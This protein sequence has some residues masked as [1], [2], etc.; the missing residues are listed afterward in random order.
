MSVH[1]FYVKKLNNCGLQVDDKDLAEKLRIQEKE[2]LLI[3]RTLAQIL[4]QSNIKLP[5][6]IRV[7]VKFSLIFCVKF[8]SIWAH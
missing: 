1:P 3:E 7:S 2:K 6:D 5:K 8:Q 4:T